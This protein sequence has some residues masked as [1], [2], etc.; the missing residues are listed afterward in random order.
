MAG[1]I[2]LTPTHA[3]EFCGSV[4]VVVVVVSGA[5]AGRLEGVGAV[6]AA[7]RRH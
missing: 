7:V 5:D 6:V 2:P 1:S 4:V 3:D